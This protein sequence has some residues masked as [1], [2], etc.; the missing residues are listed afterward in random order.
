MVVIFRGC[1]GFGGYALVGTNDLRL[2]GRIKV[3]GGGR[4]KYDS[5]CFGGFALRGLT[6]GCL[7]LSSSSRLKGRVPVNGAGTIDARQGR[8]GI[9]WLPEGAIF[10]S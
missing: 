1:K 2:A 10:V 7:L 9:F 8:G 5:R 6:R 3:G 4:I